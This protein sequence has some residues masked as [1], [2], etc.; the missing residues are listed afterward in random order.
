MLAIAGG[1]LIAAAILGGAFLAIS[2]M[3]VDRSAGIGMLV[4]LAAVALWVIF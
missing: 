1:I 4:I 3:S 2:G